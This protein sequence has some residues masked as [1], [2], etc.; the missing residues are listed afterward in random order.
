MKPTTSEWIEVRNSKIHG[1]GVFAAKDIPKETRIIEYVGRKI[2]KKESD[3]VADETL[4]KAEENPEHGAV[5]LFEINDEYDIDGDVEWN[6]A[7]LINHSCNP[8][9]ETEQD[10]DE[11]IWIS[12]I[13]DIKKGEE[14]SYNYGY[15]LDEY[16]DH[17]CKCGNDNCIGYIL[18]EKHWKKIKK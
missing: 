6:T 4:K 11:R 8:N 3:K 14:L 5:Y 13:V 17:P 7:R 1:K 15:G 9:C 2:T 16:K 10:E 12:S 18:A